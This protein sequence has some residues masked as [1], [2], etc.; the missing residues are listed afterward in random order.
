MCLKIFICIFPLVGFQHLA[1]ASPST[2]IPLDSI[3]I[4]KELSLAELASNAAEENAVIE[5]G[6]R[7]GTNEKEIQEQLQALVLKQ[8]IRDSILNQDLLDEI[9]SGAMIIVRQSNPI[10]WIKGIAIRKDGIIYF[11]IIPLENDK[12]VNEVRLTEFLSKF[13][14]RP[15]RVE[16]SV[17][18]S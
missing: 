16:I 12:T 3:F 18:E 8:R 1:N 15:S 17:L 11:R 10:K 5:R 9:P 7:N 4:K 6:F 13:L 2:F 14:I